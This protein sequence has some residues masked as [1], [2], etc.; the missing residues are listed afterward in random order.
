ML[1]EASD[2]DGSF[3]CPQHMFELKN[4][5]QK[6]DYALLPGGM[7]WVGLKSRI[8]NILNSTVKPV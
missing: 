5:K 4:N 2:L 6:I 7:W 3:V 8:P 1:K